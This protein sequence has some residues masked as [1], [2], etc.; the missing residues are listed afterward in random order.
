MSLVVMPVGLKS[1]E[2][3]LNEAFALLG[4]ERW[5]GASEDGW[6]KISDLLRCP[7]RYYLKHVRRVCSTEM[8]ASSKAQDTGSF[9]HALLAAYY[10]G[11]LSFSL[12]PGYREK[13]PTPEQVIEA[14][15]ACGAEVEALT[16]AERLWSGYLDFWGDDGLRPVAVEMPAGDA[17]VHTSRYD[18]VALVEDGIHDGLWVFDHKTTIPSVD[19][20]QWQLDGEI[21]GEA[22]SWELSEE[23]TWFF[24]EPLRGICINVLFKG[25]FP[26]YQRLW[27]PIRFEVVNDFAAHRRYW[28]AT[29]EIYQRLN[30]W[31]RSHY[32]CRARYDKCAFW[33]HCLTLSDSFLTPIVEK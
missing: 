30:Y 14:L 18:L 12:Y 15:R 16:E 3:V 9:T 10:A 2:Q 28:R 24:D 17:A 8:G 11:Q 33:D 22:L 25:K 21:L 23:S 6:S 7:Y 1:A 13:C 19:L 27:Q 29:A 26:K 4:C 31:P 20:D 5:G 32:G